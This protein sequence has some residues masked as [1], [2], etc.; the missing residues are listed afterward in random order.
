[1]LRAYIIIYIN[2][3]NTA[4]SAAPHIQL[5]WRMLGIEPRTVVSLAWVQSQHPPTDKILKN[6]GKKMGENAIFGFGV[7]TKKSS[8]NLFLMHRQHTNNN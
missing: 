3:S 4:S 2:L 1:M 7:F 8:I 6:Q 5:C